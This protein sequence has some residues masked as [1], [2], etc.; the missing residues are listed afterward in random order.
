MS[1]ATANILEKQLN[2]TE[3]GRGGKEEENN[4]DERLFTKD[5]V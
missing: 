3:L 4:E 2:N 1:G 5:Y